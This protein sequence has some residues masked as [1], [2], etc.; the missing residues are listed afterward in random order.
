MVLTLYKFSVTKTTPS[1]YLF[2]KHSNLEHRCFAPCYSTLKIS[3]IYY[4]KYYHRAGRASSSLGQGG[5]MVAEPEQGQYP[6][7]MCL[8]LDSGLHFL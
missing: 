8:S 2:S 6:S 3:S 5:P 7:T 4:R 1:Q